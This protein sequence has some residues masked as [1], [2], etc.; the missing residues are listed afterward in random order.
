[1]LASL[2]PGLVG[3]SRRW[4]GE[5]FAVR[6]G[7]WRWA[8]AVA[9]E[10]RARP[11]GMC[12][13][14]V[15]ALTSRWYEVGGLRLHA[16]VATGSGDAATPVVLV[17]GVIVSGRYLLPVAV[18][19]ARDFPVLVPDL[20]GYGLSAAPR[21]PP[22]IAS[23]AD[24][25]IGCAQAAGH[26]RMRLVGNSFGAQ[27]AAAAAV[28]HP[29]RVE[30]LVLLGPP[31]DPDARSLMP[32]YLRWQRCAVDEHLSVLPLMVRDVADVG[33]VRAAQVLRVMLNDHLEDRLA[34]VRCPTLIVRGGRD[35]VVPDRW[36]RRAASLVPNGHLAIMPGYAHMPHYSGPLALAPLLRDF[37]SASAK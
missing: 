25:V 10:R 7:L 15:A 29:D 1:M 24:A 13:P 30:R 9:R 21:A 26:E 34:Q 35:R 22:T 36:A 23:L 12:V 5:R 11:A 8:L 20:P 16:R 18:E 33:L 31:V 14:A 32:Q 28:R 27:V 4:P 2:K 37:L 3:R 19:L 6:R 17:H